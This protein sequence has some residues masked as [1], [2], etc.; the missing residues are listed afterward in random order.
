MWKHIFKKI[1]VVYSTETILYYIWPDYIISYNSDSNT[2]TKPLLDWRGFLHCPYL[3]AL[4]TVY[5]TSWKYWLVSPQCTAQHTFVYHPSQE[6]K[7]RDV[8]PL[9]VHWNWFSY[10]VCHTALSESLTAAEISWVLDD[11]PL[12]MISNT[13]SSSQKHWAFHSQHMH[14]AR[15]CQFLSHYNGPFQLH[16][17]NVLSNPNVNSGIPSMQWQNF[18][19]KN[20]IQNEC[21]YTLHWQIKAILLSL[22]LLLV[23]LCKSDKCSSLLTAMIPQCRAPYQ[24]I[25]AI[26]SHI[27][28]NMSNSKTQMT[29]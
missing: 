2:D 5:T 23:L 9:A 11:G 4:K 12:C 6:L 25:T 26:L 28:M 20:H 24:M 27:T 18:Y 22:F 10:T 21:L 1:S 15:V 7:T 17:N 8:Y 14:A 13:S 29:L 16:I 19:S 3:Q